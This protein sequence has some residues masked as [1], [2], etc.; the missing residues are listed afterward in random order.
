MPADGVRPPQG[1]SRAAAQRLS[2]LREIPKL[3]STPVVLRLAADLVT[4]GATSREAGQDALHVAVAAVHGM[5]YLLT[6]NCWHIAN[7]SRRN[8]IIGCSC[9]NQ[10]QVLLS[11]STTAPRRLW[12]PSR[13][14]CR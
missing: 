4:D 7:A 5:H 13:Y 1:T 3:E 11:T 8:R 14:D 9:V 12:E 10:Q 2:V 6:W